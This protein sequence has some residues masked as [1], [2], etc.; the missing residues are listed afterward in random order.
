MLKNCKLF[1]KL[2]L[3][4]FFYGIVFSFS[5]ENSKIDSLKSLIETYKYKKKSI[6]TLADSSK[7]ILLNQLT[8]IYLESNPSEASNI[9]KETLDLSNKIKYKTGVLTSH[10]NLGRINNNTGDFII[11]IENLNKVL[12]QKKNY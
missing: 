12:A 4:L 7:V 9:A 10:S 6:A 11:A 5:Q 3:I 1:K 2:F 8:E